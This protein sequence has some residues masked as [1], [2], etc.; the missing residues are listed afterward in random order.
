MCYENLSIDFFVFTKH[1]CFSILRKGVGVL[2][3]TNR[4]ITSVYS[5][6]ESIPSCTIE[7]KRRERLKEIIP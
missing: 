2:L 6:Q 3:R 7:K 4:F 1:H 5:M